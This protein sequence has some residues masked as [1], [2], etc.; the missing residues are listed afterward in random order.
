M[1]NDYLKIIVVQKR[2]KK[3]FADEASSLKAFSPPLPN[4]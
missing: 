3:I 1:R 4:V 2:F